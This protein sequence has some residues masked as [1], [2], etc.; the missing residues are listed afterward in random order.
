MNKKWNELG[1]YQEEF[2][3][4]IALLIHWAFENKIKV[5]LKDSFRDERLHGKW[6]EKKGYGAAFSVHKLGLAADLYTENESDHV[7]LHDKWDKMGG[8]ARIESDMNHY[9]MEWNGRR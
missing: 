5:R 8:S 3:F 6:G 4:K 9:S 7:K 1:E 2:T